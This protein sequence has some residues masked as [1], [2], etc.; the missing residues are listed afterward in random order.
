MV[1]VAT[2]IHLAFINIEK[3]SGDDINKDLRV[4]EDGLCQRFNDESKSLC[5]MSWQ[6]V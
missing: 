4:L 5:A 3:A 6:N 1:H 2:V